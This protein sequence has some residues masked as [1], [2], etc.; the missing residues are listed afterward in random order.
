[1]APLSD[2][3]VAAASAAGATTMHWNRPVGR[4]A[5]RQADRQASYSRNS[6]R[7]SRRQKQQAVCCSICWRWWWWLVK[8]EEEGTT[9]ETFAALI[10]GSGGGG[11]V[12]VHSTVA[13]VAELLL[14]SLAVLDVGTFPRKWTSQKYSPRT[15]AL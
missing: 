15:A 9:T 7:Q 14:N 2:D 1:M 12:A 4:Q 10:S 5:G 3:Q 13:E 8:R 6:S 11:P